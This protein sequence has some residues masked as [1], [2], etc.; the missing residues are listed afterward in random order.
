MELECPILGA[1]TVWVAKDTKVFFQSHF[2]TILISVRSRGSTRRSATSPLGDESA[3]SVR[4]GNTMCARV[5]LLILLA[6]AKGVHWVLEQPANSLMERHPA[7][8]AVFGLV[9]VWR[10]SVRMGEF[11]AA[12]AKPTWLYSGDIFLI[13]SCSVMPFF[14]YLS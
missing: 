12:T 5:A 11:A 6:A 13:W 3:A 2:P 4:A 8:Q 10:K 14:G 7:M 1:F 9:R